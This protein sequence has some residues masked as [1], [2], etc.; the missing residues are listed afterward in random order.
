M[1]QVLIPR[2]VQRRIRS[3]TRRENEKWGEVRNSKLSDGGELLG[4]RNE[5]GVAAGNTY[6]K[7]KVFE[8]C[9]DHIRARRGMVLGRKEPL[10]F[11][12]WTAKQHPSGPGDRIRG[13]N[14]DPLAT[15]YG[16]PR[17]DPRSSKR[18]ARFDKTRRDEKKK[19]FEMQ[20]NNF[21]GRKRIWRCNEYQE[22]RN[23][24]G[25]GLPGGV[26]RKK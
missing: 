14:S 7:E 21:T 20:T 2:K 25:E 19:S 26:T 11:A 8:E 4:N 18:N 3:Q 24:E 6:I 5:V 12:T 22:P 10:L 1:G 16:F 15:S 13:K 9:A 23:S 17:T